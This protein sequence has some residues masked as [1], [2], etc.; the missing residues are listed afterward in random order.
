M[1]KILENF[2]DD[3][4][5]IQMHSQAKSSG[6]KLPD[7]HGVEK[8][9]NPNLRPEKQHTFLKQG[10]LE[11]P[12]IGQGSC[13]QSIYQQTFKLV[14]GNSWKNQN[15]NKKNWQCAYYKECSK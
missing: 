7:I 12:C 6:I 13:H 15:R 8:S 2:S 3:K 9:L 14:T 5:L 11:R 4:Y 10:N 1:Y